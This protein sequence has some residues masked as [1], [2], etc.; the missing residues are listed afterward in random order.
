MSS[1][2]HLR[3]CSGSTSSCSAIN[4]ALR[5]LEPVRGGAERARARRARDPAGARRSGGDRRAVAAR[6]AVRARARRRRASTSSSS[7][8]RCVASLPSGR[9]AR[10]GSTAA[11]SS[12]ALPH[13][14]ASPTGTL[15]R[16]PRRLRPAASP[17]VRRASASSWP[18]A[19]RR[20]TCRRDGTNVPDLSRVCGRARPGAAGP[21]RPRLRGQLRGAGALRDRRA[22]AR[23][24]LADA[25][26][27]GARAGR[28]RR[29]RHRDGGRVGGPDR[30]GAAPLARA[31]PPAAG[32]PFAYPG[33][34][35]VAVVHARSAPI[36]GASRS[37]VGVVA[38]ARVPPLLAPLL[39]PL[40]GP[41]A[42]RGPLPCRRFLVSA[43]AARD[44]STSRRP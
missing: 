27:R 19:A 16:R 17:I 8:P 44:A 4:G 21:L 35:R 39:R 26:R 2:G 7:T 33:G 10:S 24:G 38:R 9:R 20:R 41:G 36:R 42:D 15:G 11:A 1:V 29:R 14:R 28:G 5:G 18:P 6:D 22:T 40:G 34:A 37:A 23:V 12:R 3:V 30:R 43:A 25:G 13:H 31:R 32:A